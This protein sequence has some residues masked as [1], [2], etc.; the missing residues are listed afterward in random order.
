MSKNVKKL[1]ALLLFISLLSSDGVG[2]NRILR[3]TSFSGNI[4]SST[5][6]GD[7]ASS[8]YLMNA[9]WNSLRWHI[10]LGISRHLTRHLSTELTIN[11][12]R[13]GAD[14]NNSNELASYVRNL[15]FKNDLKE[16]SL[17]G[18][19]NI[20]RKNNNC[21]RRTEI[22]PYLSVG[23][24]YYLHNPKAKTPDNLG[25][26]W[27][28]LQALSTEGEGLN[29]LYNNQYS[30]SGIA[31]PIGLGISYKYNKHIDIGV[32]LIY[33]TTFTDYLDDVSGMYPNPLLLKSEEAKALTNRSQELISSRTGNNRT[34]KLIQLFSQEGIITN[35]PYTESLPLSAIGSSR[36]DTGNSDSYLTVSIKLLYHIP[37]AI[38]CPQ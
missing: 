36:G 14:D 34:N 15:H 12:I 9:T 26:N 7:L 2:Q 35:D 6:S 5:Y 22:N 3:Y 16:L 10:G 24:A 8:Q 28:S 25:G 19:Y 23:V 31:L 1:L 33:R 13:L 38:K 21:Y 18:I 29:Q 37:D 30:L 11:W 27:V 4:G 17:R 20:I 32:E